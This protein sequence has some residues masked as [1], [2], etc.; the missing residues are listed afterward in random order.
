M[1]VV[2][3]KENQARNIIPEMIDK[4][5]WNRG[6]QLKWL[7][8][9]LK[10]L[11]KDLLKQETYSERII[12]RKEINEYKRMIQQ[13]KGEQNAQTQTSSDTGGGK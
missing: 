12:V 10:Q 9:T 8:D 3:M 6:G 2:S 4:E 7:V 5:M 11:E 13:L 1:V